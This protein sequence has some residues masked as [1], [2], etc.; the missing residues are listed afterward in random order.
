M[1]V[2]YILLGPSNWKWKNDQIEKKI[3]LPSLD[4]AEL[5]K[6]VQ[7]QRKSNTREKIFQQM[8]SIE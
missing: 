7:Q 5:E 4:D 3:K 2:C 8:H 1:Y 6:F